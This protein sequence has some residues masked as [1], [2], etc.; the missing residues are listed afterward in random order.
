MGH[1]SFID[2]DGVVWQV[3]DVH[4]QLAERRRAARRVSP[5]RLGD[6]A[7]DHRTGADR[8]RRHEVRV[9]VR[10]GY[11]RGW[12]AFDSVT[13]SR[14][15]APIPDGWDALSEA[16][17]LDLWQRGEHVERLRRRLIE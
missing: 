5:P 8:R 9:P 13:G 11:E 17:L 16:S 12:L 2:A 14:R 7:E 6:G 15:L 10:E 3:W 4:P 1:R